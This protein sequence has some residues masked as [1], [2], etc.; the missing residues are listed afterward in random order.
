M[1][2]QNGPT[3][4][5]SD[6]VGK[7]RPGAPGWPSGSPSQADTQHHTMAWLVA[8][9]DDGIHITPMD[10]YRPHDYTSKCWCRPVEDAEEP[11]MWMHNSLDG[12]EA[13]E[14]GERLVS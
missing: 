1:Q 13:F 9:T 11:D 3:S 2:L 10:D 8:S 7:A 4:Q 6:H 5:A 14:T 12:R